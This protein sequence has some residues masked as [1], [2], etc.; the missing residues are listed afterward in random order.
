MNEPFTGDA[1][2]YTIIDLPRHAEAWV[3]ALP[4]LQGL[5]PAAT[6]ESVDR[7]LDLNDPQGVR[8]LA[9]SPA[10]NAGEWPSI[11]AHHFALPL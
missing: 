4:V 10:G 1:D 3:E 6:R 9:V 2:R 5:R 7:L 11:T 8:F